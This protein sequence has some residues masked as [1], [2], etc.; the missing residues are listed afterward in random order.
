ML[1]MKKKHGAEELRARDLFY[2]LWIPDLFMRRVEEDAAWTLFCPADCPDLVDLHGDA[3]ERRYLEYERGAPAGAAGA[4]GGPARRV[5][6]RA[7]ELWFAVLDAQVETGTPYLLY[8]DACNAK[9]NHAH[10][11]TIRSSNL[12]T[13]VIQYSSP[14]EIAVCNLASLSLPHFVASGDPASV[15]TFDFDAFHRVVRVVTRNLDRV[16][17][18]NAYVREE[19]RR[20]NLRHRPMGLGVQGLADVLA[21]LGLPF[22]SD[23]AK[24]LNRDLFEALYFAALTESCALAEEYGP[25]PS[26]E[27]SP[28]SKGLL[29]F[30]LWNVDVRDGRWPWA[31]LRARIAT[32]GLRNSLL[33]APMPTASTA[34][35]LGNTECFEP[36]TS[37]LYARRVLS[38]E[39][40]V[41]NKHL[42]RALEARGLWTE[43]VRT[44][45]V[46]GNGS[47]QHVA[48]IPDELK[49]L[50]KTAWELKMRTLIDLAA[51]RAPFIDQS[52]SLNLFVA[53]P[54]HRKLSSMHFYA[55]RKGLK[56]G[57]YYL[58]TKPSADA[59]KV[60]VPVAD[61]LVCSA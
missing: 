28:A 35:I 18:R 24:A 4:T 31:E 26:Y 34:Q 17:D 51:D 8:K 12:C 15:G 43:E 61:C 1:D 11:G 36:P 48:A 47:V 50:F 21:R 42:V 29:Q 19:A 38:G 32:H 30:D 9:S 23:G 3:F 40:A 14:D 58:R 55:W 2:A 6:M 44:A 7:Q 39:F 52:Q 45:I 53:E 49:A 59:V 41:G 5:T 10:L 57:M 56:T 13:E 25:H 37:N 60:T 16:I 33:V 54:S 20:S 27:G 46:A 22:D